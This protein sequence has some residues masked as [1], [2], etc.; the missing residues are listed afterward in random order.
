MI[1]IMINRSYTSEYQLI[2]I[3]QLIY[4]NFIMSPTLG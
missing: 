4:W 1:T 2:D 3:V